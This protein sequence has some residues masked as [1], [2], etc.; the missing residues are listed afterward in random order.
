MSISQLGGSKQKF[1]LV[2]SILLLC[3]FCL[4][5]WLSYQVA[6]HSMSQ[7]IETNHLPLTSDTVYS[8]IQQDLLQP[9]F[10]S[11]LMA[12]D[13]FLRDWALHQETEVE[14]IVRYLSTIQQRYHTVTTFFVSNQTLRYYHPKGVIKT[15]S[16][17]EPNDAWYFRVQ[18]LP[19]TQDYETNIDYD[20]ADPTRTTVFVNYKVYDYN[21]NLIGVTGVGLNVTLVKK[22]I[23]LYQQRYQRSVYFIDP[24]GNVALSD[25]HYRGPRNIYQRPG[26]SEQ[27]K[28]LLSSPSGRYQ[29]KQD[30]LQFYLNARY[31]PEF[32][33]YLMVEQQDAPAAKQ[34]KQILWINLLISLLVTF[35]VVIVANFTIGNYQ[36]RLEKLASTDKLT[37]AFNRQSFETQLEQ[38]IDIQHRSNSPCSLVIFDVDHFKAIND[39]YGHLVGDEALKHIVALAT[40]QLRGSDIICRWG[41]EEFIVLL[42][43]CDASAAFE[44]AEKIRLAIKHTTVCVNGNE[45]QLSISC[46]I[47][48]AKSHEVFVNLLINR[49]DQAMYSA[50][51]NGRNCSEI[52]P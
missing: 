16:P 49:A 51:R 43:N 35:I 8:E 42:P 14:P 32:N 24:E 52:A 23:S 4:T 15:L 11:S 18:Q 19:K 9:I 2:L 27:A 20:T 3:S 17:D 45:L 31:I 6:Y 48:Q 25:E 12:Q 30:N 44:V 37:G 47:A 34:L 1:I 29:F 28:T 22:L 38:V 7:Q 36:R 41:G 21:H 5:S 33:W 50:K 46:G 13:T 40:E 26:L 39:Q 10:I